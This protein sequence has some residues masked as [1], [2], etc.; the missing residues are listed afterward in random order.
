MLP[1]PTEMTSIPVE[2]TYILPIKTSSAFLRADFTEYLRW[3]S[4]TLREVIVVDAS[5]HEVFANHA[6]EW[7][8]LVRHTAPDPKLV[9]PMGKVGNVLTGI[10]LGQARHLLKARLAASQD[11]S[12]LERAR[13]QA[14]AGEHSSDAYARRNLRQKRL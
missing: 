13:R 5:P 6:K 9:T 7:G 10:G 14:A 11:P 4:S 2:A 3:L 8:D 1:L 12:F